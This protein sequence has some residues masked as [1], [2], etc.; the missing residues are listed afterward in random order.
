MED[1]KITKQPDFDDEDLKRFSA[2]MKN[3]VWDN[4]EGKGMLSDDAVQSI[5]QT[6]VEDMIDDKKEEY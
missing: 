3:I 5:A 2:R 4:E 6:I 1:I